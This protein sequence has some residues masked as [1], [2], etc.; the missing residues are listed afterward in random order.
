MTRTTTMTGDDDDDQDDDK[1]VTSA[2]SLI[3]KDKAK[4]AAFSHAGVSSAKNVSV[5]LD[6]EDGKY[7]VEFIAGG[8][9]Y[10][11]EINARTGKVI[12]YDRD[13]LEGEKKE[14]FEQ[15]GVF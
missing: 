14:Y 5:I 7:D 13:K 11:Y 15:G 10:D 3:S 2:T 4:S 1:P 12:E 9:E 8:Y 6:K